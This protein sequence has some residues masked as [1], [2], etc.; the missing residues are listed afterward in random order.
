V[1][2]A[3]GCATE[4]EEERKFVAVRRLH[5]GGSNVSSMKA[6]VNAQHEPFGHSSIRAQPV[7]AGTRYD[8]THSSLI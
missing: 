8:W 2:L 7:S 3:E 1:T 5:Q 6:L 4:V